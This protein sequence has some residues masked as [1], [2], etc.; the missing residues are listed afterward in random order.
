MTRRG[1]AV[2]QADATGLE[3]SANGTGPFTFEEWNVGSSITLARNDDYWGDAP[4]IGGVTF[5]YFTDPNAAVNAFTTGDVDILTGVNTELVGPLAGQPGL[6]RQRGHDERRVHARASTTAKE[7]FTDPTVRKA[8]R[9]A[10]DKEAYK[11]L[12][13]G[14]GTIIGGPVPPTDPVV[15]GPHRRRAVRRRGGEGGAGGG[16]ATATGS[17]SRWCG[18]TSTR[19]NNAEFVAL[20]AGRGRHQRRD[21]DRRVLGV[22]GAG[23][24]QPR[25]RHDR[26]APRR[27]ARHRQLRQP[28]LL[29]AVRQPRGPAA[30]RRRQG[31]ARSGRGDR[32][33]QAGRPPDLRGLARSTG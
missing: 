31:V 3:N 24:H 21:P 16:R 14:F 23:V 18:R 29:L 13:N 11:E 32:A 20:P 25:L 19:R 12:H 2:L 8:I 7:P 9:Q 22:A 33:A 15:R 10:I 30:D 1:G 6:R 17:T 5:S 4:A 28:R 26:R 27:A